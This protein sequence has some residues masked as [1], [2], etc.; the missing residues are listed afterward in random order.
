MNIIRFNHGGFDVTVRKDRGCV[1][2]DATNDK[3]RLRFSFPK[4]SLSMGVKL[5]KQS[6]DE[7]R[8]FYE[9]R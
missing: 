7:E 5:T 3:F 9:D 6:I 1:N 4:V 8:A 2:G